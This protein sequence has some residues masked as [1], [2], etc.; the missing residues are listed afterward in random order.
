MERLAQDRRRHDDARGSGADRLTKGSGGRTHVAR[1]LY[2]GYSAHYR[3]VNRYADR[4]KTALCQNT[5]VKN[6]IF[7]CKGGIL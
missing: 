5:W 2:F 3:I 4:I 7:Y 1:L 6:K